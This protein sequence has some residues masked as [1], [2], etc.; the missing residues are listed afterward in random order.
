MSDPDIEIK[1][2]N[3]AV[4]RDPNRFHPSREDV[5]DVLLKAAE[6]VSQGLWCRNALFLDSDGDEAHYE[7]GGDETTA[8]LYERVSHFRRCAEGSLFVASLLL[9]ENW[10]QLDGLTYRSRERVTAVLRK[11]CP[12][13]RDRAVAAVH[14]HNDHHMTDLDA[15]EAGQEWAEIFREAAAR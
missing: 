1:Y 8:E 13:C 9:A 6:D 11:R 2:P 12:A 10:D 4:A 3:Y 15:F 5:N 7:V 14:Y